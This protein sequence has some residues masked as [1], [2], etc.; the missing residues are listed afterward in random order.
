MGH[1]AQ[2]RSPVC[3]KEKKKRGEQHLYT[4]S[5]GVQITGRGGRGMKTG[6]QVDREDKN[7]EQET[8]IGE[9]VNSRSRI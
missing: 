2:G 7:K 3:K 1:Q 8:E 9:R 4:S 5:H 6:N